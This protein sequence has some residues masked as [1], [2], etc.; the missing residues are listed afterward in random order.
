MGE[1]Y[2]AGKARAVGQ[3]GAL[4]GSTAVRQAAAASN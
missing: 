4:L 3:T 1:V 2:R